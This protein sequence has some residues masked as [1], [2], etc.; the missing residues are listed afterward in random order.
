MHYFRIAFWGILMCVAFIW[1]YHLPEPS[2]MAVSGWIAEDF[3]PD[4]VEEVEVIEPEEEPV[5]E[6]EILEQYRELYETNND[7]IGFLYLTEEYQYPVLQRVEDQNY[8]TY[9]NFLGEED[10]EGC[11]FANRYTELGKPGVSMLYGHNLKSGRMF[12]SLKK[13]LN[14]DY[15]EEHRII[16]LDTLYEEMQ[17]EVV[18]VVLT[19]LHEDFKYFEYVGNLSEA[20]FVEWKRGFAPYV[21]GGTIEELE[22]GDIICELS[23]CAYHAT[24]GRLVVVL[25]AI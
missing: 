16:K 10:K 7:T 25:K 22:Y 24:D 20:E 5:P 1:Q 14:T 21:A 18:A 19:S 23:C 4:I 3:L 17:Y 15:F 12:A 11:I 6:P 13:Y 8:Y 2:Y 9:R